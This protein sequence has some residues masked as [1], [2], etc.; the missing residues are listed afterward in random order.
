MLTIKSMLEHISGAMCR[1]CAKAAVR[2]YNVY[3]P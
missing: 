1:G 2:L 3:I